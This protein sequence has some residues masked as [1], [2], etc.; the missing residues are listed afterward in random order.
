MLE[1]KRN[2]N[3]AFLDAKFIRN[4]TKQ[5]HHCTVLRKTNI[6]HAT[7]PYYYSLPKNNKWATCNYYL[8]KAFEVCSLNFLKEE[9]DTIRKILRLWKTKNSSKEKMYI[10]QI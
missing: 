5:N 10:S 6:Y 9:L 7:I 1:I 4:I 3:F 8:N 2:Q